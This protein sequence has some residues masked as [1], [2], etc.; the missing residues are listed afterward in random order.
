MPQIQESFDAFFS[1]G[2]KE[3]DTARMYCAGSTEETMSELNL[4][5][6]TVDSKAYPVVSNLLYYGVSG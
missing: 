2:Q 3:L 5:D 6:A 1:H 4:R